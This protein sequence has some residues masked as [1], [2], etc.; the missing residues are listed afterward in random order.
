MSFSIGKSSGYKIS[1]LSGLVEGSSLI[2]GGKEIEVCMHVHNHVI[3]SLYVIHSDVQKVSFTN[4]QT[5]TLNLSF[6]VFP[7]DA[8][9]V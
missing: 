4:K 8:L 3:L 6:H 1:E 9:S 7:K 2:V 5:K